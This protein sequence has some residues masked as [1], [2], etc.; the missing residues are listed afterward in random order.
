MMPHLWIKE[1]L[2]LFG[3]GEIKTLLVNS[4]EMWRVINVV[5]REFRVKRS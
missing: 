5:Y 4:T 2:G 3:V 1:C